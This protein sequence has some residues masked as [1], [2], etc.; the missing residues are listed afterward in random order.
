MIH[1]IDDT[2]NRFEV[3]SDRIGLH[4]IGYEVML[5]LNGSNP[6]KISKLPIDL[7]SDR[8]GLHRIGS[9]RMLYRIGSFIYGMSAFGK[10]VPA[11]VV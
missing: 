10:Y 11:N 9:D 7:T 1:T 6:A 8:I 5:D 4:R 2:S 3:G